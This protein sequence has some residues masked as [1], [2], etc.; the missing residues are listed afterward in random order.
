MRV[1]SS[2]P[3][4]HQIVRVN[5]CGV[6]RSSVGAVRQAAATYTCGAIAPQHVNTPQLFVRTD[7][8]NARAQRGTCTA[9][10]S[11]ASMRLPFVTEEMPLTDHRC[12]QLPSRHMLS[13]VLV[14][15]PAHRCR[16]GRGRHPSSIPPTRPR[17]RSS[18][19][20]ASSS[21][22]SRTRRRCSTPSSWTVSR[23]TP[24]WRTRSSAC[25]RRRSSSCGRSTSWRRPRR[26]GR[27]A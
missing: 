13:R 25:S 4:G 16:S 19:H 22:C 7:H 20:C 24:I 2:T 12:P 11:E 9:P 10:S 17:P 23:S 8:S 26:S 18:R 27:R 5:S 14:R 15:P 21:S 6:R 3:G 1:G